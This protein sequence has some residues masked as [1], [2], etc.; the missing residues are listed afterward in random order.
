MTNTRTSLFPAFSKLTVSQRRE[1]RQW[2]G[3]GLLAV[4]LSGIAPLLL[5]AGRASVYAD[6]VL[7]KE[8]FVPVLVIHVNLSVG[9]WFLAMAMMLWRLLLPVK[10]P[11]LWH[12]GALGSF[13][14]GILALVCAPL[15]GGLAF[16]SN[17]IPV[18]NNAL[19]FFGLGLVLA[20][21]LLMIVGTLRALYGQPL[22][23]FSQWLIAA[24]LIT[25]LS[26]IACFSF[27]VMQHPS[28]YGGESYYEAVFWAGGHVMQFV[29]VQLAAMAWLWLASALKLHLPAEKYLR[30]GFT[31]LATVA[32]TSP[33][34]FWFT[35]V[36]S[37]GHLKFFT[38]Q[39]DAVTGTVPALLA[40]WMVWQLARCKLRSALFWVMAM[41]LLLF[42][43]GGVVAMLI[44][45]TN[46]I[47][48]AHYHGSTVGVTLAL[49]GLAYLLLPHLGGKE[50]LEWKSAK[51]QP[52]LYGSGQLLHVIGFAIAGHEGAGRKI[53]GN[54]DGASELAK[55]GMQLVRLGGLLA[56]IGGGLFVVILLRA[57]R[58]A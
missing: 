44:E 18:Q 23:G 48:P 12:N 35:D 4:T 16:T 56:V 46:T 2:L 1:A 25:L 57:W 8:W 52:V 26:A 29:Y 32:A 53:A 24:N 27:S 15:A 5:L 13:L 31:L 43:S 7:V 51:W 40:V 34:I 6:M 11:D 30:G 21:L 55:A 19:F 20:A 38:W 37:Y 3:L 41:S 14:A 9:L 50:V 45:G 36:N 39:M 58:K 28:G 10:L 33:M 22:K 54:M 42:L 17:Y 49:M 47:I